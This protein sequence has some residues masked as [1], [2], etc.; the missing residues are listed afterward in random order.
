V[1]MRR[2]P[3]LVLFQRKFMAVAG[4]LELAARQIESRTHFASPVE[5]L[6]GFPEREVVADAGIEIAAQ[7]ICENQAVINVLRHIEI[8]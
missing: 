5:F 4:E 6:C 1:A 3:S 7:G 2:K 8:T